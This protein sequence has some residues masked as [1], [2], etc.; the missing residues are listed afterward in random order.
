MDL[1]LFLNEKKPDAVALARAFAAR[2][3]AAG[4][5]WAAADSVVAE[6]VGTRGSREFTGSAEGWAGVVLGGDGTLLGAARTAPGVPLLAVDFGTVGFLAAVEPGQA[7]AAVADLVA[8]NMAV[9]ERAM[10]AVSVD[11]GPEALAVNEVVVGRHLSRRTADIS[12]D[13]DGEP[14]WRWACDGV[15]VS[16]PTGSTAYAL[17]AGGPLVSP[18]ADVLT[19]VPICAHTLLGKAVVLPGESVVRILPEPTVGDDLAVTA[20]GVTLAS[21]PIR[22]VVVRRADVPLRLAGRPSKHYQRLRE[23]LTEWSSEGGY[24]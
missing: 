9:E 1:V 2:W 19:L 20:D 7:E 6:A 3:D 22:A 24:R 13:I 12:V 14:F 11:G 16:T 23:K 10:I 8:G 4:V 17:S 18:D 5:G 21:G 15:L